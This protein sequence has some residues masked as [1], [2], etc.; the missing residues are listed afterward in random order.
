MSI[1]N[2]YIRAKKYAHNHPNQVILASTTA[3]VV[4]YKIARGKPSPK[5]I[6]NKEFAKQMTK[7]LEYFEKGH[8]V[9]GSDSFDAAFSEGVYFATDSFRELLK[10]AKVK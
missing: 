8:S 6:V 10:T 9:T 4:G 2:R 7:T 3:F 5:L 1:Q